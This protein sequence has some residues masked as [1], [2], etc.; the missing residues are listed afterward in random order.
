MPL[1]THLFR[2]YVVIEME[3]GVSFQRHFFGLDKRV[4]YTRAWV[5]QLKPEGKLVMDL[6]GHLSGGLLTL[7]KHADGTATGTFLPEWHHISFMQLRSSHDTLVSPPSIQ[8]YQQFPFVEGRHLAHN[9]QTYQYALHFSTYEYFHDKDS[10]VNIWLQWCFPGLSIKWK[11]TALN[12]VAVLTDHL[13]STVATIE[14]KEQEIEVSVWG[15]R[16]LWSE[17]VKAYQ[18]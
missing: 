18:S 7:T 12:M 9:E 2:S 1:F 8:G 17:I 13:T 3:K 10:E 15:K 16:L 14:Q 6:R 11:R 5:T 4:H